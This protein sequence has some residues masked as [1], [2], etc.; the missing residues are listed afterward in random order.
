M[1]KKFSFDFIPYTFD[2]LRDMSMQELQMNLRKF[3][4]MIREADQ[5]GVDTLPFETEFCYLEHERQMRENF[6]KKN[7]ARRNR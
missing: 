1:G 6:E 3:K 4:R 5:S 2:Q 7:R